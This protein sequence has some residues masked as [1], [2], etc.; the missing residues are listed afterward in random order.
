MTPENFDTIIIGTGQSGKPLALA[1]GR[2][3]R[4][5][6]VPPVPTAGS[7]PCAWMTR[8]VKGREAA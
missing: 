7:A 6:A 1:L 5:T 3:G 2:A 8:P 4:R